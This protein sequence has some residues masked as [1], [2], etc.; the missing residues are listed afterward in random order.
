MT[1]NSISGFV[2]FVLTIFIESLAIAGKIVFNHNVMTKNRL[3]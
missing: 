3:V 1:G 2:I